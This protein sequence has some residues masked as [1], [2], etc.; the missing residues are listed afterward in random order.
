MPAADAI[1][2]QCEV[3]GDIA[4]H[5]G[6]P[7]TDR[8]RPARLSERCGH[9]QDRASTVDGGVGRR[10]VRPGGRSLTHFPPK[11]QGAKDLDVEDT[12]PRQ[13]DSQLP[14]I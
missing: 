13:A 1:A 2:G 7:R 14:V 12:V 10:C 8:D 11:E 6:A 9:G 3:A 4:A 5:D